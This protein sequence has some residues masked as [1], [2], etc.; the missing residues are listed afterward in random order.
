[1]RI[2]DKFNLIDSHMMEC[3]SSALYS[4]CEPGSSN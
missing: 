4:T 2:N 3:G 1:M